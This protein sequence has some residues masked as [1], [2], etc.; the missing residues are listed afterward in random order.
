VLEACY[1]RGSS[2][3]LSISPRFGQVQFSGTGRPRDGLTVRSPLQQ[4]NNATM[5]TIESSL[6]CQVSP[7]DRQSHFRQYPPRCLEANSNAFQDISSLPRYTGTQ[8]N[9]V[10]VVNMQTDN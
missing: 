9:L 5:H 3:L 4:C 7:R 1:Q 2:L 6:G 10:G 8:G